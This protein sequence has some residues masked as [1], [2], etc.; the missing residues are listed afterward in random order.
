MQRRLTGVLSVLALAAALLPAQDPPTVGSATVELNL[1]PGATATLDGKPVAEGRAVVADL[2][3]AEFRRVKVAVT[4][5][6]G[7]ADERLVDL[8]AGL[9]VRMA[10]PKPGPEK[11]AT[12]ATQP[13]IPVNSAAVSRDGRYIAVGLE[14]RAVVLWDT[15]A[16]RPTRM[17]AGHQKVVLAVAFSPD[18]KHLVSGSADATAVLWDV[19]TGARLRTFAGH[20]GSVVSA[21]FTPDGTRLLTGSPDGT[22][23]LWDVATA[24]VVF[25]LRSKEVLGVAISPDGAT[26][27]TA[28]SG[29]LTTT[30][31]DAR[32]GKPN[33]VLR[34]HKEGVTSVAF[35]PD[36]GRVLTGSFE[37]RGMVWETATGKRVASTGLHGNDVY[38][39]A[40]TP[41]GRRVVTGER[42]EV[43]MMWEAG[44][45]APVRT[46]AGHNADIVSIVPTADGRT[47]VSGSR[48]GTVRLW[49]LAT[50]RE[51]L[52]LTTDGTRKTWA[53]VSPDGLFDASEP[54]RR[55]LGYRFPKVA[56]EI[57][58]LFG[59]G[60]RPGLLAEV[61]RGERP[62]AA[63]P[64]GLNKPPL[65]RLVAPKERVSAAP[66]ATLSADVTDQGGGVS[67]LVV[68]NNGVRVAV[69]PFQPAAGGKPARVTFAV[70]LVPG[71]NRIRVK[72]ANRD[73]SWE[74]TAA[75]V[76]LTHPRAAGR[77]GRL[78]VV[79]VGVGPSADNARA[80]AEALRVRN[81]NLHDRVDV[82][83]LIGRAATR[84][85]VEDTVKDVAELTQ[86]HDTLVVLLCG[87]GALDGDRLFFDPHDVGKNRGVGVADIAAAMCSAPALNRV[88]VVDATASA[89]AA[90]R[91]AEFGLRGAVERLSRAS[92]V[93]VA[94]AVG[95]S[96]AGR[97]ALASALIHAA[98]SGAVDVTDW[99]HAAIDACRD[100]E[101]STR[102][103]GFPVFAPAK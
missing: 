16:G 44:T 80:V 32:T 98:E 30:L 1:P 84:A 91:R 12:I 17:L 82:V 11:A 14:D 59:D 73:G 56:G 86:P 62:F 36:G 35:S 70:P 55:V 43:V 41:D 57:D 2:K 48:D 38:S 20:T 5:A 64:L 9:R 8:T 4:F 10:V 34:G 21:A 95:P 76:E 47:L 25:T 51:L 99:F 39:V 77:R 71:P 54:G 67:G 45:G 49:D 68:E 53:V 74:S 90:P 29:D 24:A 93:H 81:G 46:F 75:E 23:I 94:A 13:L 100:A 92:G 58:Q 3:P 63:K 102:T 89:T 87:P 27:A 72:A 28:S 65:V 26:L 7:T 83:P 103:S 42:E 31:W 96:E 61:W 79:A 33:V 37:N 22:A 60:F 88:L 97:G 85:A 6:D 66:S 78:Y 50:G 52:T 40:F 69:P 19:A 15:L 18:G 101:A